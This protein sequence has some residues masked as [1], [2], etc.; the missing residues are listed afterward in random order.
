[1]GGGDGSSLGVGGEGVGGGGQG[2]GGDC[3]PEQHLLGGHSWPGLFG[4]R[5]DMGLRFRV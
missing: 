4:G 5:V 1:M 2:V 3:C